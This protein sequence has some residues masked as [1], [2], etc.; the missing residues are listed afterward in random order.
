MT[1]PATTQSEVELYNLIKNHI[2]DI[3][4]AEAGNNSHMHLYYTGK[5]WVA[6]EQSAFKLSLVYTDTALFPMKIANVPF[7][8]VMASIESDKILTA[9][10]GLT[11]M[12]RSILKRIYEVK[13]ITSNASF[14]RWHNKKTKDLLNALSTIQK[15]TDTPK[16][17]LKTGII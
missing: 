6:F 17:T 9:T 7:P 2:S 12:E 8:I 5:Y 11:C 10:K 1:A 15:N 16:H 3:L 14:R 13:G 4:F